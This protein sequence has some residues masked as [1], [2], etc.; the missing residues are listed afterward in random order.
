MEDLSAAA[1]AANGNGYG[2]HH[3][4]SQPLPD[5]PVSDVGDQA[6]ESANADQI[7]SESD[8]ITARSEQITV[9]SDQDDNILAQSLSAAAPA[10]GKDDSEADVAGNQ[11]EDEDEE[12]DEGTTGNK[13]IFTDHSHQ[14]RINQSC[15]VWQLLS[16]RQAQP[17]L[18]L[19]AN[20]V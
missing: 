19:Y 14:S 8:Q 15:M 12:A 2:N 3:T 17:Y 10:A 20:Q 13:R 4:A 11:A 6:A 9:E 18:G 5:L 7:A 16:W 1:A